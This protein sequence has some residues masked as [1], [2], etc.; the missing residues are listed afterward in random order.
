MLDQG[1]LGID[2]KSSSR[3][4]LDDVDRDRDDVTDAVED[5]A[6]EAEGE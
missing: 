2:P 3:N 5:V 6:A 1:E 4:A